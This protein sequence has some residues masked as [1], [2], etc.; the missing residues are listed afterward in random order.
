MN[1]K[2]TMNALRTFPKVYYNTC[3]L[4]YVNCTRDFAF[5]WKKRTTRAK[6]TKLN[7]TYTIINGLNAADIIIIRSVPDFGKKFGRPLPR[8]GIYY[9]NI[10]Y[11]MFKCFA[12]I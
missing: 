11:V 6:K 7:E 9:I 3:L 8:D 5:C 10:I 2:R 1:V 4:D 12:F